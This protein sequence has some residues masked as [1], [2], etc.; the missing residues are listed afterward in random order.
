MEDFKAVDPKEQS[1]NLFFITD[2]NCNPVI[3]T[4]DEASKFVELVMPP[5]DYEGSELITVCKKSDFQIKRNQ[6]N[7]GLDW[8]QVA[9]QNDLMEELESCMVT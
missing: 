7:I 5:L 6:I 8:I 2:N 4:I 3:Y 9:D 1:L